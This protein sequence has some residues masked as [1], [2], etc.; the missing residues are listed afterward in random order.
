M[1]PIEISK[2][3]GVETRDQDTLPPYELL[4]SV[5]ER[6]VEREESLDEI[7]AQGFDRQTV[8]RIAAMIPGPTPSIPS[9][10][11]KT[12]EE[13]SLF[14]PGR[15]IPAR[16]PEIDLHSDLTKPVPEGVPPE[17]QDQWLEAL[18]VQVPDQRAM[19]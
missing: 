19:A 16:L 9:T 15:A 5:L 10:V 6:Y 7:V 8:A 18:A 14:H 3:T 4:D 2:E 17:R 1:P 12:G 13:P 11:M